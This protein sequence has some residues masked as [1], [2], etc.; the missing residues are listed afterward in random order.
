[1]G[2]NLVKHLWHEWRSTLLLGVP[3]V[4]YAIQNNLIFVAVSNMSAAAAQVI[5]QLKTLSTALFTVVLLGR[6]F[7]WPQYISFVILTIGV[8]LVQSQDA[9]S[10]KAPTGKSPLLGALAA[11]VAAALSGFAGCFL[12]KMF[13]S[14]GTSLWMR[15]VQ[16]RYIPD[17]T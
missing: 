15:N 14:G 10:S 1:M 13:T 7:R 3:A 4:C 12:E 2:A 9:H 11:L 17:L 16:V 8:I 5:Y 6:S